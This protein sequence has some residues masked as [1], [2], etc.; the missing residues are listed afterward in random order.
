LKAV[1]VEKEELRQQAD[2]KEK[3]KER[4]K[5]LL[6]I[7]EEAKTNRVSRCLMLLLDY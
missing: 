6:A 5:Q 2:A 4:I 7:E 1:N 3:E